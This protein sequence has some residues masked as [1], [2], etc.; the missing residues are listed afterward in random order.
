M[1][2]FFAALSSDLIVL[3]GPIAA[4]AEWLE[5]MGKVASAVSKLIGLMPK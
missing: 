1:Y 3:S 2:D 4:V 5:P